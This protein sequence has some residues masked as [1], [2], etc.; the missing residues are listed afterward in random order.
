M[1]NQDNISI[2]SNDAHTTHAILAVIV[3]LAGFNKLTSAYIKLTDN[4]TNN[5]GA[6]SANRYFGRI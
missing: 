4:V 6:S 1:S 5:T 3:Q 2:I